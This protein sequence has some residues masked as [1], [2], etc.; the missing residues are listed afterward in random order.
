MFNFFKIDG[1]NNTIKVESIR[2]CKIVIKGNSNTIFIKENGHINKCKIYI[3]SS[4][5]SICIGGN[6]T[7]SNSLFS[8]LDDFSNIT[9][10]NNGYIGGA[11]FFSIGK[12]NQIIIGNHFLFSD[13][14]ELWNGDGH[15]IIDNMS[16]NRINIDKPIRIHDNVWI[17]TGAVIL[18]GVNILE[19]SIIGS[20]SLVTKD[21]HANT[22]VAGNPA[23]VIKNNISWK[24]ER[25]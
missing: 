13:N 4:N 18:K 21:I 15:S 23:K 5:S 9:L 7:I 24:Y 16:M 22:M 10:G 1:I 17:G 14:I 12:N 25:I 11:R 6:N 8:I 19:N 2:H 3:C 20:K